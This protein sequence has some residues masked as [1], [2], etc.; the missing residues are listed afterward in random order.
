MLVVPVAF[1]LSE[2]A[3]GAGN[4]ICV[5]GPNSGLTDCVSI[6]C[7]IPGPS[8]PC[9]FGGGTPIGTFAIK[10]GAIGRP[11][12]PSIGPAIHKAMI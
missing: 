3:A 7:I 2:G 10:P 9:M 1:G 5:R 11:I 4:G 8:R 12:G 6:V